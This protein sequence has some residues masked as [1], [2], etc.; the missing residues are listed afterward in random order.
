M[1]S[2][3]MI[4]ALT[5]RLAECPP[6]FLREP[7]IGGHGEI[8]TA[9]VVAD[10]LVDLGGGPV[11]RQ[12]VGAFQ[13]Q[14]KENHTR[15]WLRLVL[16]GAWLCHFDWFRQAGRF[17]PAVLRFLQGG[18]VELSRFVSS[19]LFVTDPDRREEMARLCLAA[20]GLTPLGERP[21]QAADRLKALGSVERS[22]VIAATRKKEARARKLREEMAAQ[23]AREAAAK[24]NHE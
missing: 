23:K 8:D 22:R 20:L 4:E 7:R 6:D 19:D 10:L 1:D 18:L 11:D 14:I 5:R 21:G 2:G 13:V 9:A 16:L 24:V 15:N 12:Q 17:A 3:P